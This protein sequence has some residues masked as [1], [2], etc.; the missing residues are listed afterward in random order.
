MIF[1]NELEKTVYTAIKESNEPF[2]FEALK[3]RF[4]DNVVGYI[5]PLKQRG[6]VEVERKFNV[7]TRKVVKTIKV[8]EVE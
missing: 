1:T 3:K 5:G 6:L 4:G 7:E 8:K 2:T